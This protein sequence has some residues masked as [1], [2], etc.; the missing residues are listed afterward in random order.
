[1]IRTFSPTACDR[2]DMALTTHAPDTA[3]RGRTMMNKVPEVTIFFWVIKIL[4]TTVG[5]TAADFLNSHLGLG[6][7]GTTLVMSA[8]LAG[9]LWWQFRARRYIPKVYW[10]A[11]VLISV[12]G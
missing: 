6:L 10:L 5:E 3:G 2:P 7:T 12:V 4:A 8:G 11:V 9:A 1:M